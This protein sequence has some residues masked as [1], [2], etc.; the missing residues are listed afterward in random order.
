M[1]L[2]HLR[3][4]GAWVVDNILEQAKCIEQFHVGIAA[5]ALHSAVFIE[6]A[7]IVPSVEAPRVRTAGASPMSGTSQTTMLLAPAS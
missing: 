5:I 4:Q 6:D 3:G 1:R 7:I 2:S